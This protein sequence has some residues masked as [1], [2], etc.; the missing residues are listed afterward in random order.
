MLDTPLSLASVVFGYMLLMFIFLY[1]YKEDLW[2]K[3]AQSRVGRVVLALC[4]ISYLVGAFLSMYIF[5]SLP[6]HSIIRG[7]NG[8][9]LI[10]LLLILIPLVHTRTSI[11]AEKRYASVVMAGV[12]MLFGASIMTLFYRYYVG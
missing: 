5:Y 1:S 9:Y 12:L 3:T 2:N 8:R 6:E 4:L 11:V 10:P 7:V